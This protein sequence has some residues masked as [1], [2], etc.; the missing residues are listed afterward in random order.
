MCVCV[1]VCLFD[2]GVQNTFGPFPEYPSKFSHATMTSNLPWVTIASAPAPLRNYERSTSSAASIAATAGG[3][4]GNVDDLQIPNDLATDGSTATT[5]R[6]RSAAL[7][8][9]PEHERA[10]AIERFRAVIPSTPPTGGLANGVVHRPAYTG[11][12]TQVFVQPGTLIFAR[13]GPIFRDSSQAWYYQIAGGDPEDWQ[14][15]PTGW[16]DE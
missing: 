9:I 16:W 7:P 15:V 4:V 2:I 10:V 5:A 1:C 12:V 3:D 13:W 8:L 6:A 11:Y 14:P